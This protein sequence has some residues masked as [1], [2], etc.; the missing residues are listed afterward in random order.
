MSGSRRAVELTEVG[1]FLRILSEIEA[2]YS[3]E[4]NT[5]GGGGVEG[6]VV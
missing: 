4:E 2:L 5:G 6:P 3:F 1:D